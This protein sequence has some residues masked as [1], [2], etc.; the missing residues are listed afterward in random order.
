MKVLGT[1]KGNLFANVPYFSGGAITVPLSNRDNCTHKYQFH[2]L[3]KS[4]TPAIYDSTA[5]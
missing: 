2:Q 3:S 4:S 5:T 1:H